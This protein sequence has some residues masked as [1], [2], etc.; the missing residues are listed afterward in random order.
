MPTG[1]F[2]SRDEK[3]ADQAEPVGTEFKTYGEF[4][5]TGFKGAVANATF[6]QIGGEPLFQFTINFVPIDWI[7]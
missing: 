3:R 1:P 7:I 4:E 2:K 5:Y 6:V